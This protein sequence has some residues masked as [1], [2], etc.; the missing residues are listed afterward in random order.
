MVQESFIQFETHQQIAV[1]RMNRP[2]KRNALNQALLAG[3]FT[4]IEKFSNDEN[5]NAAI[6]TGNGNSFCAG[7]DLKAVGQEN[8][9]DPRGDGLDFPDLMTACLKPII[10]AVNG[11]AITGGFEIALNCDFLIASDTALFADTHAKVKIHPGWGMT[12]LLQQ[13]IGQRRAKQMSFTAE[14]IHAKTA[15]EWGLVNEVTAPMDLMPRAIA[16]AEQIAANEPKMVATIKQLIENKNNSFLN[17]SFR[18]ERLGFYSF[19]RKNMP[20][21]T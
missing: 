6:L 1:I 12:Q 9:F 10:G 5:L 3:L 20:T 2:E 14:P 11:P 4:A 15:L 13:A 19:V 21:H 8:L 7:L 16:L 17:D 18:A